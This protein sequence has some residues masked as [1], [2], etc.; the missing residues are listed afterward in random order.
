MKDEIT[1]T[2]PQSCERELLEKAKQLCQLIVNSPPDTTIKGEIESMAF[3]LE[4]EINLAPIEKAPQNTSMAVS[5]EDLKH[6][7]SLASVFRASKNE[8]SDYPG[9]YEWIEEK[10]SASTKT[11]T[12]QNAVNFI[13]G[14]EGGER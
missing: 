11:Q 5:E 12:R 9:L 4:L 1:Q 13:P 6:I 8:Y 7:M 2:L 10:K 3:G 14:D